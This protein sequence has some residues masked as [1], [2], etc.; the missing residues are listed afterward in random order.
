MFGALRR[1]GVEDLFRRHHHAEVDDLVVV[2]AED[3]ADDVLAD[4][5][6][7][8]LHRREHRLAARAGATAGG[9]LGLHVRLEIGDGALH[10]ARALHH[11]RE[12]HL[13]LAEQVAD[14]LHA[15]HERP[16]DH[17]E[18]PLGALPRLLGVLLDEVDDA[19]DER[20]LDPLLDGRLA[21]REVDLAPRPLAA[22]PARVLDEPLGRVLA[23]VED[24]VLD[25]LEE[26][27]LDVLV[28]DELAGVD[29]PHVEPGADR[30][31]EERGVHRLA[32][33][34][35]AAERE[36]EV[37]DPAARLRA[38]AALLDERQRLEERLREAAMLVDP[39]RDGEDVRVEDQVLGREAGL[40]RE[41]LVRALADRDLALDR[42]GL[43]LAR[44]TP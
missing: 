34:V 10:R 29:D 30:V 12:E 33:G 38:G 18:R 1:G 39:R 11:L 3:D 41:E 4:V 36:A 42:V 15:G 17:V 6:D 32:H 2:A 31:E 23:P 26:L 13:P 27:R 28:H 16:F 24:H 8:A 21:P 20:V 22:H 5:V 25:E 9:L 40:L 7:V 43:A 35:V 14:D 37:R 19:V 44:R